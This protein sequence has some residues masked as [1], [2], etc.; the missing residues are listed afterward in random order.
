MPFT[1]VMKK[2]KEKGAGLNTETMKKA[3]RKKYERHKRETNKKRALWK[4]KN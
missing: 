2:D 4:Q 3:Y 1:W